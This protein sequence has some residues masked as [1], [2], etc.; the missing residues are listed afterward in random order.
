MRKLSFSKHLLA[1]S[2]WGCHFSDHT[3]SVKSYFELFIS[4][5]LQNMLLQHFNCDESVVWDFNIWAATGDFQQCGILTSVDSDQPVQPPFR[6]RN[7]KCVTPV[8]WQSYIIFKRLTKTL[9]RLRVCAGWPQALLLAHTTLLEISCRG[10]IINFNLLANNSL[11]IQCLHCLPQNLP[12]YSTD[13][14]CVSI[15]NSEMLARILISWIALKDKI[16]RLGHDLPI[17]VNN[18]V[19]CHFARAL[20][21]GKNSHIQVRKIW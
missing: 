9:I 3:I 12:K 4:N 17:S 10:S 15:V 5:S 11:P 7:S 8:A 13:D 2:V 21:S 1:V 14:L 6:L 18:R 16:S 20:F 19:I